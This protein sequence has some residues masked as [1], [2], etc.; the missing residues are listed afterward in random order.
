MSTFFSKLFGRRTNRA[1][2]KTK[3]RGR[4]RH[5]P[6][7]ESLEARD[8]PAVSIGYYAAG[9]LGGIR[10]DGTPGDDRVIVEEVGDRVQ[11]THTAPGESPTVVSYSRTAIWQVKFYGN[12]GNDYFEN[13][14]P[15]YTRN[16]RLNIDVHAYGGPGNDTIYGGV[17]NDILLGE[18]DND[19]VYGRGGADE[20]EGDAGADH[21]F[22]GADNDRLFGGDGN[23]EVRGE[24][25]DDFLDGGTGANTLNGGRGVNY[26]AGQWAIAGM[27]YDDIN[28]ESS[29]SCTFLSSLAAVANSG[30]N[31]ADR[32]VYNG[33]GSYQVQ[34]YDDGDL[35]GGNAGWKW[36]SASF[37]GR[38]D[39]V[40]P[41]PSR[42]FDV[43]AAADQA[44]GTGMDNRGR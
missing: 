23:D 31:L 16:T 30:G 15:A 7:L 11:V 6:V 22:G 38:V 2:A 26:D 3:N 12:D 10:I 36:C 14:T 41:A 5:A 27:T 19:W 44:D 13:A 28:Q 20:I 32:I 25:G 43:D 33:H 35:F 1:P 9:T 34:L 17:A 37:D 42:V 18:G 8:L 4:S 24:D 39:G 21:L 29:D 40:D